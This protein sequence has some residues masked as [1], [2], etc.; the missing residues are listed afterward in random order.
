[1]SNS[2]T[3]KSNVRGLVMC[4]LFTALIIVGTFIKIPVPPIPFTLQTAFVILAG[5]ALG[6]KLGA[7]SVLTYTALGL[8]G[9][10]IF[11]GGSGGI[12]YI[13]MPTFGYIIGFIIAAFV[14]GIIAAETNSYKR[15]LG[16]SFAGM[17][18]I[19]ACGM[20]YYYLMQTLYMGNAVDLHKFIISFF[21]LTAPKDIVTCFVCSALA[22]RLR[23]FY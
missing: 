10:P 14:S 2:Q 18:I 23:R 20:L 21:L 9:L 3:K 6:A 19:Y 13:L 1:M 5:L 8:A 16:A 17:G 7:A 4:S 11:S 12:G 15:C 22:L